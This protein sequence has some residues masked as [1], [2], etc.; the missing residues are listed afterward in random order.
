M[1]QK[2]YY[3]IT[4][5]CNMLGTTSRTLRFMRQKGLYPARQPESHPAGSIP[6]TKYLISETSLFCA[7]LGCQSNRLRNCKIWEETL[8]TLYLKNEQKSL[9]QLTPAYARLIF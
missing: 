9:R 7:H 5:V 8:G 3:D 6:R 1:E 4:E 2:Q